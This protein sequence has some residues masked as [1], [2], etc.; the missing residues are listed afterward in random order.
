MTTQEI[1]TLIKKELPT[2]IQEDEEIYQFILHI[3]RKQFADKQ[4]TESRFDRIL[5]ELRQDR[6][7][8]HQRW[9]EQNRKWEEQNRKWEEQNRKWEEQ[10]RKWDKNDHKWAENQKTLNAM[11]E[12][13]RT[14]SRKH[15]S[16]IGA[17]GARWGL[18]TEE[19]FRSALRSILEE[20][21]GVEVLNITEFDD[22]GE[23]FGQPDQVEL[24]VIIQNG[25]LIICEIKSSMSRSDVYTFSRKVSFYER[26]HN[27]TA[28]RK[29]IISPM[30]RDDARRT[31]EKLRLEVFSY[32]EDVKP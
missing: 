23:V 11:L 29:M 28:N 18:N 20:S 32:A 12:E 30:V 14:L 26:L 7:E 10:N 1:K 24:D 9:E 16:T 25:I 5:E 2:I 22:R 6:L 13:I 31:A 27:R 19:S 4:E 17:L 3:S 15:D 21:F 8:N